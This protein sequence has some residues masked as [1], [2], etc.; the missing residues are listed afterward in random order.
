MSVKGLN[1]IK[2]LLP[3]GTLVEEGFEYNSGS[4]KQWLDVNG[5]KEAL[6]SV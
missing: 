3:G 2:V 5:L 4:N 6:K 1:Q